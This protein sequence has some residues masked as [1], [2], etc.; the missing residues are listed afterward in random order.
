MSER[1]LVARSMDDFLKYAMRVPATVTTDMEGN[2]MPD[3]DSDAKKESP[4]PIFDGDSAAIMNMRIPVAMLA[5]ASS[6]MALPVHLRR[7]MALAVWV[8]AAMLDEDEDRRRG[9]WRHIGRRRAIIGVAT[10]R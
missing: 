7:Q 2:E 10:R 6:S 3:E 1:L 5:K 9:N 8:K 4:R